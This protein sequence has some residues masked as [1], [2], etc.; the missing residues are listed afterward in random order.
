MIVKKLLSIFAFLLLSSSV[1]AQSGKIVGFITDTS[2]EPLPGVNIIIMGTNQGTATAADGYYQILNVKPGTYTLRA[3]YIGFTQVLVEDVEV[4]IDL[5]TE[6]DIE[7]REE[8]IEG[9]EVTVTARQPVI[10]KDVA[11][12]QANISK[13]NIDALPISSV[14]A[15]VGLQAGVQGLSV[16]GSG[17]DEVAFNLNGFTLRSERNNSPFTGI[18]LTS[19]QN[20]QVQTGGFSAEYGNLRS[21][22]VNVTS[23]EGSRDRYTLDGIVRITPP[24][25]KN[26]GQSINDPNSYWLRPYLDDEVAWTGTSNG[27]WDSYT[28]AS[29]PSFEGWNAFSQS[30]LADDDPTNDLTP[31]A[32]Q[33]AF[34]YQHRKDFAITEPD[35]EIDL[36]LGGPVPVIS[37]QL[38]DLRFSSSFRQTQTMYMVPLSRDR[39]KQSTFQT[40]LTSNV[41]QGMKLSIDGLYSRETGTGASQS[42]NP[43]FFVSPSGI[44][45]SM[46]SVSYIR[47]RLYASD[48]WAPSEETT[49]NVG[50]QFTHSISNSTFYEVKVNNFYTSTSTNP[51]AFRD[52][53][54]VVSIGGVGFNQAPYG[55]YDEPSFGLA[56]GMR[57]GV[58]MSTSRDSSE[59]SVLTANFSITSQLDRVNQAKAGLEFVRTNSKVNYGSFDKFLPSGRTRSVW[60]TTPFRVS[61]YVQDKLEFR[62]MIANLGLRLTYSDPNVEWYDYDPYTDLFAAGNASALDT[63]ATTDVDPQLVLQPR[64]GVSFPITEQ[65]KLFFNY[66]HSVQLPDPENLYLVRIEPF[67][68][69]VTRIAA[70]GNKLPKTVQYE[71]GYEHNIFN[72]YLVRLSGYYKDLSNQP[73]QVDFVGRDNSS[74]SVSRAFS[75]ED[76]RGFEFTLR[77]QRGRVFWGEI[78]YTYS[79]SSRGFFGTLENY[80][81]PAKQRDYERET[82]DNDIFRPVPQPYARLQLYFRTPDRFG[83]EIFGQR[84][85]ENWQF[86]PL[87]T[88]QAGSRLTYTGGGSKP[89][90]VNNLQTRDFWGTSLRI[91]KNINLESGGSLRFFA[92]VSNVINRRNFNIY[93]A[94]FVDGNDFLAYMRS[95]HLP[96]DKLAEIDQ[97]NSSV[98][99]NDKPGA[100]RPSDVDYVPIETFTAESSLN[101]LNNRALYYN[102]LEG[103]Y[104]QY[105]NGSLVEADKG[106]V[107]K[108]LDDKAYINMPNQR[109]FNFLDPRT[110]RFGVRFSF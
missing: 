21:G 95:L 33:Q 84:P 92:D 107:N 105:V 51:G 27:A 23:K 4:N 5:T 22:L 81:N 25:Q 32:A 41:G 85:L 10:K 88:W 99:G 28:Q 64:L 86:V 24:Q 54:D 61:A 35:Y 43:G 53:S 110:I 79:I 17:S 77:K 9:E 3:T 57:M 73:I 78:N 6:V 18:S 8:T 101:N 36:T 100:Y 29:Y 69:T 7:M 56:T 74:Y 50:F 75:Y 49:A 72:N 2:G 63:A 20:V 87:V 71:L 80:E 90:V 103:K 70:P 11:S 62:G 48:Y 83:P 37:E 60:N 96:K 76:I 58:G 66:G 30:T 14:T 42:G 26:V 34:L 104:Y 67:T 98:P 38:G 16:R 44:A 1:F 106:Y 46:E 39:Y 19:V 89:G 15:A 94:G 47:S 31:Q 45:N 109:F 108:V 59:V 102:T 13:E 68:N 65:S 12:S 93:N 55:F 40:R 82:A 91:T 52:T 97:L